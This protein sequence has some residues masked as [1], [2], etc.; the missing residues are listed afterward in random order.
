MCHNLISPFF[1]LQW[2]GSA[3]GS[4]V[5]TWDEPIFA[6]NR[7]VERVVN[8]GG[9]KPGRALQWGTYDVAYVAYDQAGNTAQCAFKIYVLSES[10]FSCTC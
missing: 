2:V 1:F 4:A 10:C 8:A 6:D 5:V 3:N 7:R 9:L